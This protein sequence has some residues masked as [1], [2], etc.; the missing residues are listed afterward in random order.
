MYYFYVL[1]NTK[2]DLYYGSTND[3]KRRMKEH[4]SGKSFSTRFSQWE[5]VYY[6]A[7]RDESDARKRERS[8]K[9]NGQAKRWLK[10]RIRNSLGQC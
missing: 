3:L 2:G 5:L 6:E 1:Q 10:E 9:A 7:Y 8:I 4:H